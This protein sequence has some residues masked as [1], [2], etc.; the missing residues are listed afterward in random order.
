ML[1]KVLQ[2]LIR[3]G[4][5]TVIGPSG[6]RTTFG[7]PSDS[8]GARDVVVRIIGRLTPIKLA[9]HPDLYLG[10]AYM[11]G[12]LVL[13]RGSL[14][15]LLELFGRNLERQKTRR[16]GLVF[17][18]ARLAANVL[19]QFNSRR[20]SRRNVA[21][22]YDLSNEFYQ[23]F[24]DDDLQYSCAYFADSTTSLDEAQ[25]AKKRLLAAKLRLA[26]GQ[27]ILDIG[28]GWG[29]LAL[30]LAQ[31]E[32]VNVLGITLSR[33]QLR[34]AR[35]RAERLGLSGRVSFEL[36]DYRD[37]RGAF[38]RVVSVGMLEHVGVLN[39]ASFFDGISRLLKI[40]GLAVV[41]SIGRMRG[42][43]TTSAWIR[44]YI[45]PGGYIP[46]LSQV[47]PTIEHAGLWVTDLEILRLHYADTLRHWRER[48]QRRRDIA[49]RI[50]DE[51]FC[52]M[53]EF[54][55]AV[56]EMSFRYRGFMVF[57]VQLSR[58]MDAA[59]LTREY[60]LVANGNNAAPGQR[61]N[62]TMGARAAERT[63]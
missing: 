41:H 25:I 21:H 38:D 50:R 5:L 62:A 51:R 57:Q 40:D 56:S 36:I 23:L 3:C 54:Y 43:A 32:D 34:I 10:E 44:K 37:V 6:Q 7:S 15:D 19:T 52:R 53:W 35:T 12:A 58:E 49:A 45:F 46:A 61:C 42:P 16:S 9:L 24:L 47:L 29:G 18:A 17:R 4:Q 30:T 2:R 11:D 28:C 39:Y 33:E 31:M 1:Q 14:W 63:P 22:H 26:P 48:F 59:P 55:L 13:E 60:L 27:Q 8:P 20:M